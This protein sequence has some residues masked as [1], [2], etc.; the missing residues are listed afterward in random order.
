MLAYSS[1]EHM[2]IL[3]LGIGLG[4]GAA[5]GAFFHSMNNGI[6][7]GVVFLS[8]GNIHRAFGSKTTG[9]VR[10]AGRRLPVSGPLFLA[11]FLALTGS[12]PF[13]PF[14][15]EFAILNGAFAAGRMAVGVLFLA[16]LA[17]IF[18]G[19]STTVL[20]VVQGDPGDAPNVPGTGDSWLTAAPPL[21][22]MILVLVLGLFLPR[23]LRD[24]FDAAARL[25]GGRWE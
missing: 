18:I 8:A 10:G 5:A 2:G 17:I 16:F 15:S 25:V 9:D 24:L 6:T 1:V 12:P 21:A 13:S 11:G 14:F 23:G 19:M 7:K 20:Q 4:G 22:L 3:A